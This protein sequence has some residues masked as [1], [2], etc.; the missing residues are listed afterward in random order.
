MKKVKFQKTNIKKP[1]NNFV[2][3]ID[4][5]GRG[6]LAGPVYVCGVLMTTSQYK[7][8]MKSKIIF[9]L[10]DSKKLSE[11]QREMWFENI[12]L[13]QKEGLLDFV[14]FNQT[15]DSIDKNGISFCIRKCIYKILRKLEVANNSQI[16]L[17]G[18][19]FAPKNFHNQTTIIKGDEKV[20]II[21]LAS[22]IA[23]VTRDKYMINISKKFFKYNFETNKGYGTAKHCAAIKKYG[24]SKIHRKSF[25]SNLIM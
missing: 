12:L 5:V 4:E 18:S 6:P 3:G 16:L 1:Q 11:K 20:P 22:I 17:D 10:R 9:N 21:S 25:C 13:W 2:V 24:I 14:C 23:K 8:I 7:K 19:L 15:A